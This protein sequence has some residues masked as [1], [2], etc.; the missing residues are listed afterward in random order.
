MKVINFNNKQE[1]KE[2]AKNHTNNMVE[3]YGKE[4]QHS[5][6]NTFI[7]DV[8]F[9]GNEENKEEK[10]T[11]IL[12][13]KLDSVAA[14]FKYA[15]LGKI[16]ILNFASY[17]NPGGGFINGSKAQEEALCYNSFLY[18]VLKEFEKDFYEWNRVHLNKSLY[19]NRALYTK[20]VLFFNE[21]KNKKVYCDV[22][23]CPAPNK[24][25]SLEYSKVSNKENY[26]VLESRI[27]FILDI[28]KDNNVDTL[29]LG[30]F[31]CG[32]FG[33]DANEVSFIFNDLLNKSYKNVFK[34]VIFAIP[35]FN[36][37][38]TNYDVFRKNILF[39]SKIKN[40]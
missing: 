21:N 26:E 27:K 23:T 2:Y 22:I 30:A 25:A 20:D 31:G 16:A 36:P 28:A 24:K 38:D 11:I 14:I 32:V 7:Y 6:D 19:L 5:I 12:V 34:N 4:I 1:R 35:K 29:I 33:Q 9:E 10:N 37:K 40:T 8:D 13:D 18:N 39:K 17:K 3:N 15:N